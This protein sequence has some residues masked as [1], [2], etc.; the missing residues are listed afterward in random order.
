MTP[1]SLVSPPT[2]AYTPSSI[3]SLIHLAGLPRPPQPVHS[4][5]AGKLE[6]VEQPTVPLSLGVLARKADGGYVHMSHG[7]LSHVLIDPA[8]VYTGVG[9]KLYIH[10]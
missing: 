1:W 10:M 4:K 3:H 5:M 9:H 7:G 8:K 6:I 2:Q